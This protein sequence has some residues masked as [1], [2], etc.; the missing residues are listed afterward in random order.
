MP[1]ER[2]SSLVSGVAGAGVELKVDVVVEMGEIVW[3]V[4]AERVG[5][6]ES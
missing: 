1:R 6:R 2:M 5:G 4:W 3:G